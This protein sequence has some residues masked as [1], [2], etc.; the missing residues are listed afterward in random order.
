MAAVT[1][2]HKKIGLFITLGSCCGCGYLPECR[3]DHG[4]WPASVI[5]LGII[6][7]ALIIAGL[8]IYT[9]FMVRE[10]RRSDQQDRFIDAVTHELKTPIASIRLYLE[11]L[12]SATSLMPAA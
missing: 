10:I 2:R 4:A 11:T 5:V 8:V 6:F 9:I 1:G 3:L 7:F 12:Q